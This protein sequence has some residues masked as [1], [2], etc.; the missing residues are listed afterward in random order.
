MRDTNCV[1][2]SVRDYIL[3]RLSFIAFKSKVGSAKFFSFDLRADGQRIRFTYEDAIVDFER[4]LKI[5]DYADKID[6]RWNYELTWRPRVVS[7]LRWEKELENNPIG[8]HTLGRYLSTLDDSEL[9]CVSFSYYQTSDCLS[10]N[11]GWMFA[12]GKRAGQVFRGELPLRNV[13]VLPEKAVWTPPLT[14]IYIEGHPYPR[15]NKDAIL[16]T[17]EQMVQFADV[18]EANFVVED[19][20]DYAVIT[21]DHVELKSPQE[22]HAFA[23]QASKLYDL[24]YNPHAEEP[25][26]PMMLEFCSLAHGEPRML[27]IRPVLGDGYTLQMISDEPDTSYYSK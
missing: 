26:P 24:L 12:Y 2:E 1:V 8:P 22:V 14:P 9:D 10:G 18:V 13:E 27:S 15:E 5:I 4:Y 17:I 19:G 21:V 3:S 11:R 6:L 23:K 16:E 7:Y 25:E 20:E